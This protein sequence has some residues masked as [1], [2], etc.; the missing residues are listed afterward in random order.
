MS[1]QPCP[2]RKTLQDYAFG[3]LPEDSAEHVETHIDTCAG[4]RETLQ[5]LESQSDAML[6]MLRQSA[7]ESGEAVLA[8][9]AFQ[10]GLHRILELPQQEGPGGSKE[11]LTANG[12]QESAVGRRIEG[13]GD[14]SIRRI[15]ERVGRVTPLGLVTLVGIDPGYTVIRCA[16]TQDIH[17]DI[18][19]RIGGYHRPARTDLDRCQQGISHGR[20]PD[21]V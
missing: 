16:E 6:G 9:A 18:T 4:C 19:V 20:V 17:A 21:T 10:R 3:F 13:Y 1:D 7:D 2:E 12:G 11:D 8:E 5:E 15:D 14:C